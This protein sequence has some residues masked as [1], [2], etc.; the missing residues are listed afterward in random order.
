MCNP[1]QRLV[2]FNERVTSLLNYSLEKEFSAYRIL[3]NN[4]V[5]ITSDVEINEIETA[6]NS[7]ENSN[8]TK[9]HLSRALELLSDRKTPDYRNSIKESI[10]SVEALCMEITGNPKATLGQAL[11]LIE[12]ST[13]LHKSLQS[14]FGSLYGWTSDADG[15][16]HA[17][18]D[19][20]TLKQEDAIFMLVSCSAFVNYLKLKVK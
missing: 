6:I 11:K 12:K 7:A 15:I 13:E 10:S 18:M 14:A 8:S 19:E 1:K 20:S 4:I 9:Q 17:M 2:V 16:R 5:E 3:N